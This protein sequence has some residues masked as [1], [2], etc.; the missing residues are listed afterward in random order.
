MAEAGLRS[1]LMQTKTRSDRS[2]VFWHHYS[3]RRRVPG[4]A[5]VSIQIINWAVEGRKDEDAER[6]ESWRWEEER[7]RGKSDWSRLIHSFSSSREVE[8]HSLPTRICNS[9]NSCNSL[10]TLHPSIHFLTSLKKLLLHLTWNPSFP[11]FFYFSFGSN[12]TSSCLHFFMTPFPS[13][14]R[15]QQVSCLTRRRNQARRKE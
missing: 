13:G 3:W 5:A 4:A 14:A 7:M 10:T 6:R 11:S 1:D 12:L 8:S 2:L 9:F 15:N